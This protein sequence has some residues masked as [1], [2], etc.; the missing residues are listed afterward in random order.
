MLSSDLNIARILPNN[1]DVIINTNTWEQPEIFRWIQSQGNIS[2]DEML[3]TFNCGIGMVL[4][5]E[6]NDLNEVLDTLSQ[7]DCDS[8]H[9]GDVDKGS[10]QIVLR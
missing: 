10:G 4:I 8:Y 1:C 2:A 3:R 6:Q 9:I 5:I 7:L